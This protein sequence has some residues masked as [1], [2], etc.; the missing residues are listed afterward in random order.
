MKQSTKII[1]AISF[2][3][4]AIHSFTKGNDSSA[5][6]AEPTYTTAQLLKNSRMDCNDPDDVLQRSRTADHF[7]RAYTQGVLEIKN[8]VATYY[9]GAFDETEI[10]EIAKVKVKAGRDAYQISGANRGF[11]ISVDEGGK[12]VIFVDIKY[13]TEW[14]ADH[15]HVSVK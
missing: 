9:A 2:V 8:G 12:T 15:C 7:D 11:I 14:R 6:A 5:A 4:A 10:D 3:G 1:L 13:G